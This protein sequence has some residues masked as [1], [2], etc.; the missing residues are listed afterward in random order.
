MTAGTRKKVLLLPLKNPIRARHPAKKPFLRGPSS[1][2][3]LGL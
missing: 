1:I 2:Q 3:V